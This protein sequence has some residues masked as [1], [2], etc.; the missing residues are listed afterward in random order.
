[1]KL[2]PDFFSTCLEVLRIE[3]FEYLIQMIKPRYQYVKEVS[4]VP[5]G[6]E[7]HTSNTAIW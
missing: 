6:V 5:T 3:I 1:M 4:T 7:R 2:E